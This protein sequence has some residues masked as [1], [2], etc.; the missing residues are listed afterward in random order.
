M[1]NYLKLT[2]NYLYV[3]IHPPPNTTA[4]LRIYRSIKVWLRANKTPFLL[5]KCF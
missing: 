2:L 4:F 1:P 5:E 3:F